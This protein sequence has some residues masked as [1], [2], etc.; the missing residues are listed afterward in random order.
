VPPCHNLL[1]PPLQSLMPAWAQHTPWH[2]ILLRSRKGT[3]IQT[4][5]QH[6][7][8][9]AAQPVGTDLQL[10]G[11]M[12]LLCRAQYTTSG[13]LGPVFDKSMHKPT[14]A[15]KCGLVGW[16]VCGDADCQLFVGRSLAVLDLVSCTCLDILGTA[17]ASL[18]RWCPT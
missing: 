16:L 17:L 8:Q 9:N 14:A 12:L 13:H 3:Q 5:I 15:S 10:K 18:L 1:L 2:Q 11:L 7:Q 6:L 4:Q